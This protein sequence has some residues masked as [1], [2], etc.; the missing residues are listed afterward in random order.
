MQPPAEIM[1]DM[2]A[3]RLHLDECG[4]DNGPLRVI[5]GSHRE[6]RLSAGQIGSCEKENSVTCTVPK[7]GALVMRPLLLH[8]S[9]ACAAPKTRRV[10]HIEFAA[11]ELPHG[12]DW[13]DTAK[14]ETW[15]IARHPYAGLYVRDLATSLVT[16]RGLLAKLILFLY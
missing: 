7:G 6:G 2:L 15:V 11:A 9:S 14:P 8:A 13:N 4:L 5:S 1:N 16:V 10:I 12:L 3:I